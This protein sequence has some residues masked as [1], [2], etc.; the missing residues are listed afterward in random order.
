MRQPDFA[1]LPEAARSSYHAHMLG[2]FIDWLAGNSTSGSSPGQIR[3]AISQVGIEDELRYVYN[4]LNNSALNEARRNGSSLDPEDDPTYQGCSPESLGCR[5]WEAQ[6][7]LMAVA[8][9]A[10]MQDPNYIKTVAPNVA[11][12]IRDAVNPNPDINRVIQFN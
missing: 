12:R 2:H 7:E 11:R 4:D 3:R 8:I 5:G 10:Y 9:R 6:A 1:S